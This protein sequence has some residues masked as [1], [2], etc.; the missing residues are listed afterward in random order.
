M[1]YFK[2]LSAIQHVASETS[3]DKSSSTVLNALQTE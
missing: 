1:K 2:Q 3:C